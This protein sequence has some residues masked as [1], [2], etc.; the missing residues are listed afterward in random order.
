MPLRLNQREG[1]DQTYALWM[2]LMIKVI[3]WLNH[4]FAEQIADALSPS[5]QQ[6]VNQWASLS[7]AYNSK[8]NE[9]TLNNHLPTH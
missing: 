5:L 3:A 9:S 4:A 8:I 1:E 2:Y 7:D 6:V